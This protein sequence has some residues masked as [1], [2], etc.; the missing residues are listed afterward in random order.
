[1]FRK[2]APRGGLPTRIERRV[3]KVDMK[4]AYWILLLLAVSTLTAFS[5]AQQ[6]PLGQKKVE[7]AEKFLIEHKDADPVVLTQVYK[8][9]F[10]SYANERNWTKVLETYASILLRS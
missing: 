7:F 1:M 4:S 8:L 2:I 5:Q 9:L 10:L 6:P 3:G